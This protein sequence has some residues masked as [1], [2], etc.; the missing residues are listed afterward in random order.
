MKVAL[1]FDIDILVAEEA[2][3]FFYLLAG[4]AASTMV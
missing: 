2:N 3:Q 4:S 1:Q